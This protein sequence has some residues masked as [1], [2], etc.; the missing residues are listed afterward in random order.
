MAVRDFTDA[1]GRSW[2]AWDIKPETIHPVTR[3]ED[4]LADYLTGWIVFETEAGDEKR[5]LCPW[6]ADWTERSE[7]QLRELLEMAELVPLYRRRP[8]DIGVAAPKP[9]SERAPDLSLPGRAFLECL[10][11]A[12]SGRGRAT[13][14]AFQRGRPVHRSEIVAERLGNHVGQRARRRVA[15]G[16]AA[17][18][19]GDVC[20][21][22]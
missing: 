1:K 20:G 11:G 6:P 8:A 19:V 3:A 21:S 4:Y 7:E 17:I 2:R 13:G 15:A 9:R 5:R 18:A 16:S 10:S 14:S 12:F 22:W